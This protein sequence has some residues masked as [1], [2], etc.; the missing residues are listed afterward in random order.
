MLARGGD[1]ER[2][3]ERDLERGLRSESRITAES[4]LPL[5]SSR[6]GC[7]RVGLG[8]LPWFC[9][10]SGLLLLMPGSL[11]F[12]L[13]SFETLIGFLSAAATSPGREARALSFSFFISVL[14][15]VLESL[16]TS[17]AFMLGGE[18]ERLTS[19]LLAD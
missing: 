18:A 15:S 12:I 13:P 10:A 14:P 8:L 6:R 4:F 3:R 9:L 7:S 11:F 16:A 5:P 19:E 1:L 2:E 17:G